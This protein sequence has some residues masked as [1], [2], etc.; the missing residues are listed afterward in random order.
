MEDDLI[1]EKLENLLNQAKK[2][3]VL[4]DANFNI[5][6]N[7]MRQ[8][9]LIV[10]QLNGIAPSIFNNIATNGVIDLINRSNLTEAAKDLQEKTGHYKD[11]WDYLTYSI[12]ITITYV[13][14][15]LPEQV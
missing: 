9:W 11:Y 12:D 3:E 8:Y 6:D 5:L 7:V 4:S 2:V 13:K 1:L 10:K 14:N 15:Y